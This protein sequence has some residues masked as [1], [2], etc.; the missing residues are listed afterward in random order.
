MKI[1][2]LL[3]TL[4][5]CSNTLNANPPFSDPFMPQENATHNT[6]LPNCT[7]HYDLLMDNWPLDQLKP[8][9]I[10]QYATHTRLLWIT[11]NNVLIDTQQNQVVAQEHWKISQIEPDQITLQSCQA[12]E[13]QK[14]LTL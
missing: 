9:G 13:Q 5:Y 12:A 7:D 10:V 2:Y 3:L 8:I 11:P 14:K 1:N 6:T 4:L